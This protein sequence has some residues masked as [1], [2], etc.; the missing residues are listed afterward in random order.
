MPNEINILIVDDD[1]IIRQGLANLLNHQDGIHV[2][3]TATNGKDAL[4]KAR[5]MDVQVV[6]LDVDMPV[7]DGVSTAKILAEKHPQIA[8]IMLTNFRHQDSLAKSLQANVRGFL[9]KDIPVEQL[10]VLIKQAHCGMTVMS[11]EPI[12]LMTSSYV[13]TQSQNEQ[14]KDFIASVNSLPPHLRTVFD[15]L[16]TALPNKLIAKQLGLTEST[17]RS[18]IS[19]IFTATGF[20][21]RGELCLTA[22]KAGL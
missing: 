8:V 5:S 9:T 6:L 10:A 2:V 15:L 12:A 7:M 11:P 13:K 22:A 14:F 17:V 20:N 3:A 19:D 1:D 16:I 18:Y 4:L 21:S